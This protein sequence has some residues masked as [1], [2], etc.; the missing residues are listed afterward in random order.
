MVEP[1]WT[2]PTTQ[3][4]PWTTYSFLTEEDGDLP[5]LECRPGTEVAV[6]PWPLPYATYEEVRAVISAAWQSD[7]PTPEWIDLAAHKVMVLLGLASEE[8]AGDD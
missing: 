1:L 8:E 7:C 3:Q 5:Q 4:G 6:V 2:G